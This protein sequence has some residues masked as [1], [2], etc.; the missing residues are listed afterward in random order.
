MAP[1][2]K[3]EETG[4]LL[5]LVLED[6]LQDQMDGS[7]FERRS[8]TT[9]WNPSV[10]TTHLKTTTAM[11]W[12]YPTQFKRRVRQAS[13]RPYSLPRLALCPGWPIKSLVSD[14]QIGC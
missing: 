13:A 7:G 12:T 11:V 5:S 3:C 9:L 2:S 6:Y 1:T 10:H 8:T 4:S 14:C